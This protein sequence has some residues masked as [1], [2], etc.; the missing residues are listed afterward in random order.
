MIGLSSASNHAR[1]TDYDSNKLYALLALA[2]SI[3]SDINAPAAV[4]GLQG[5]S[6]EISTDR[7]EYKI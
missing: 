4:G 7:V 1:N 2:T 6:L 3:Y 5:L